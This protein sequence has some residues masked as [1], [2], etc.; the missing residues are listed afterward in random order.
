MTPTVRW[1]VL[2]AA[3]L[4]GCTGEG[5]AGSASGDG[6]RQ[7]VPSE[8]D[9]ERIAVAYHGLLLDADLKEIPLD[10][11]LIFAMQKSLLARLL[12]E[13]DPRVQEEVRL[14]RLD[15][16]KRGFG[17][18]DM[19][20]AN[21]GILGTLLEQSA[22]KLR[23]R[24]DWRYRL[25]R[26]QSWR[27]ITLTLHPDV[28][29]WLRQ[30]G[31]DGVGI[32]GK[33]DGAAYVAACRSESVPTPPDFPGKPWGTG[34][35]LR[36]EH[37][38]IGTGEVKVHAYQDDDGV[39]YALPRTEGMLLGI[40]CQ[41]RRTGKACF[42]DNTRPETGERIDWTRDTM[43]AWQIRNGND[44]GADAC[45]D[46]HRGGNAF[47]IHPGSALHFSGV[48]TSADVRYTPIGAPSF[49]NP[50]PLVLPPV[51]DEPTQ[52]C[53]WCHEIPRPSGPW[54]GI[55]RRAVETTMPPGGPPAGWD[56]P[57]THAYYLHL[58]FLSDQC[59]S[60]GS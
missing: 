33:S 24:Y 13:A 35:D 45:T 49:V 40:I 23:A 53:Q 47:I 22:E 16:E 25:V 14:L 48:N 6:A 1:T 32:P 7:E 2:L 38:F 59:S 60:P 4:V 41:S 26:A 10:V 55:L 36:P 43:A 31:L 42:Y 34:V 37:N 51:A 18:E 54:C 28:L 9:V 12:A 46:C 29:E 11:P 57:A 21:N 52:S 58:A 30:H 3:L 8:A 39:C 15:A 50:G 56:P 20:L 19:V 5:P 17:T 27:L 44:L